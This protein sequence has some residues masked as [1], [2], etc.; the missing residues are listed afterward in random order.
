MQREAPRRGGDGVLDQG[1]REQQTA[2]GAEPPAGGGNRL[3]AG[4]NGLGQADG[5][6]DL[7]HGGVDAGDVD[8]GQRLVAAALE[9]GMDRPL[10]LRRGRGAKRPA[11]RTPACPATGLCHD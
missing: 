4:G 9:T 10:G 3:D 6:E 1:T 5:L 2:F 11:C 8:P 7:E